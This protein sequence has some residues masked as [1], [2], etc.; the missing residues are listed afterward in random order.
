MPRIADSRRKIA[1][2]LKTFQSLPETQQ[3]MQE[4]ALIPNSRKCRICHRWMKLF[5]NKP[6]GWTWRCFK[7]NT[8]IGERYN[9][10]SGKSR[11]PFTTI[12][13]ILLVYWV[14]VRI[15]PGSYLTGVEWHTVSNWILFARQSMVC[16]E[17]FTDLK[18]GGEGRVVEVDEAVFMKWKCHRGRNKQVIWILG[19]A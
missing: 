2:L 14:R 15:S 11:L 18:L 8:S 12:M 17:Y 9:S 19:C 7:C 5:F 10:I 4:H 3:C 1:S 6:N 13:M 16:E